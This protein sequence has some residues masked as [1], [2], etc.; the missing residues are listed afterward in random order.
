MQRLRGGYAKCTAAYAQRSLR[1]G[2]YAKPTRDCADWTIAYAAD[3][4]LKNNAAQL[5]V[6]S[7][8]VI[9]LSVGV[10]QTL[11]GIQDEL[12]IY[13]CQWGALYLPGN[14]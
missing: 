11:P 12:L 2:A 14:L 1:E 10:C 5:E 13:N 7:S 8:S 9:H 6:L 4:T 3:G